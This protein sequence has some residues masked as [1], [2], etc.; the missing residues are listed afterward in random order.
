MTKPGQT[1][2]PLIGTL[3]LSKMANHNFKEVVDFET[4]EMVGFKGI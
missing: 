1:F 3:L 4:H 2:A